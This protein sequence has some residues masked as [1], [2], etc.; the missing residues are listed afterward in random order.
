MNGQHFQEN[1]KRMYSTEIKQTELSSKTKSN[2]NTN[3]EIPK[4]NSKV[5]ESANEKQ[6][7]S[8]IQPPD[9]YRDII[10]KTKDTAFTKQ[11]SIKRIIQPA[12][13]TTSNK[14]E[15]FEEMELE[16]KTPQTSK[17]K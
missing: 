10:E 12:L 8:L 15:E 7:R 5:T 17:S 14:F 1:I 2:A 6:Q 13:I 3:A 9:I 11:N 4:E 16:N